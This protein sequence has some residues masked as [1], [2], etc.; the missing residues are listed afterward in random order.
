MKATLMAHGGCVLACKAIHSRHIDQNNAFCSFNAEGIDMPVI[1][2]LPEI[3][4]GFK[5]IKDLGMSDN[6]I[7][8][9]IVICKE[10]GNKFETSTYHVHTIK[11]CG[12]L[13]CRTAKELS[14][15]INGFRILKDF[16]YINGSRR[17]LA[18][19]K[20]C[21]SEYEVDPNKLKYRLHCGCKIKGVIANKY[22]KQYPRLSQIFKHMIA[23]C[24]N[25]NNQ[26]YYNYGNRG[27][28]ICKQW[29]DDRNKFIIWALS[30]G[31]LGNLT[32]D[33]IDSNKCYSP[34]NC[35]WS[36]ALEQARN[37]R[38]NVLDMKSAIVM[39]RLSKDIP[40]KY[41]AE[42]FKVSLGTV[43]LVLNNRIWK[44]SD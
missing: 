41:L 42:I 26:D 27:I 35:K 33:R 7:R 32:I 10:C 9:A 25:K 28:R 8:Y 1:K 37:T 18:I 44:E 24:Y 39:R 13:P 17:C 23:R 3:M 11:S 6:N 40:Q 4:N 43:W 14:K 36:N 22:A 2:R 21:H 31:Y 15:F 20:I 38:R 34:K 29:K 19:C 5:V 30:N 16:G 12:C